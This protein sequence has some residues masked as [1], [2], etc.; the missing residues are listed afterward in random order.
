M[1]FSIGDVYVARWV[2]AQLTQRLADDLLVRARLV[3]GEVEEETAALDDFDA[4]DARAHRI[5]AAARARVELIRSDGV[6]LGDS[7][8]DASHPRPGS[9]SWRAEIASAVATGAGR[10][11]RFD[12]ALEHRTLFVAVAFRREGAVAGVAC[13]SEP[14]LYVEDAVGR[15]RRVVWGASLAAML[16]AFLLSTAA[17]QW[18]SRGVRNITAA[19]RRMASGDLEARTRT[20]SADEVGELGRALDQL[21]S[22]LSRTLGELRDERDLQRRI[23][24][25]MQEGVLVL[26]ALG[27]IEMMNPALRAMLL[28]G[29]D[30]KGKLLL[31][32]V[33]VSD[34]NDLFLRVRTKKEEALGEIELP[35][36]KP[37]R[38]LA[39]ATALR[40]GDGGML[41]V[42]VDVTDLRR[43]ES[44]RRDFVANVSHELR[45]PVTAVLSA[46][47]T[48]KV[49]ALHDTD[50][51]VAER[52]VAIIVRNG[53]RLQ[54]LIEDLLELSRLESTELK[55][56][57]EPVELSLVCNIVMGLFR[58][59]AERKSITLRA[60]VPA[61][62]PRLR[63][64]QRALEQVLSNLVDNAIKYCPP[65][66]TVTL[67][68]VADDGAV[69]VSVVDNGP[70]IAEKH[71]PRLFERFYRVDAG[72]SRELGGTGLGLSIIKHLVEAMGGSVSVE[73][74]VGKGTRFD[75]KL[76]RA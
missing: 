60:E 13:V 58:E 3:E 22:T 57:K 20:T 66:S 25:G 2:D 49:S 41:A 17:A 16:V 12:A 43:L 15:V 7:V 26:D 29:T 31:E 38:L 40:G 18:M 30:A 5:G 24:D 54:S 8:L 59:R 42:F 14:L 68:A 56:K 27:R 63:T 64:D 74:K 72:R 71:L 19:A 32:V 47:E 75:V 35:G 6:L 69:R 61:K 67:A 1:S 44:L 4:W 33:R 28:L 70:G 34:L 21:A 76:P 9:Q 48:L 37:R 23:L 65:K 11:E 46:A 53:E 62:L 10:A 45:T 36:I 73:S 55:L 39:H 50:P 52:F 51:A